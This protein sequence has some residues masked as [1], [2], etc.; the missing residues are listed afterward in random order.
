M[1]CGNELP[2][3]NVMISFQGKKYFDSCV[4]STIGQPKNSQTNEGNWSKAFLIDL[5]L[6]GF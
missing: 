6:I 5:L 3:R 2:G 1:K 4:N